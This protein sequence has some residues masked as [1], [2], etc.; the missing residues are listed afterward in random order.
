MTRPTL[1]D[2]AYAVLSSRLIPGLDGGYT[3][4]TLARARLLEEAGAGT[5]TLLTVDPGAP[6]AHAE[7]RAEFVRRGDA[8]SVDRFRNLFDDALAD[9]SWL[10]DAAV[11]G[12]PTP[13][14]GYR[15]VGGVVSI[16]VIP[17]DPDWHLTDAAV[18]VRGAGV[19]AGF[20][21]L[22]LA[23][24][25]HVVDELRADAPERVVVLVCE[26]R[27]LGELIAGWDDPGV[28]IVHTIHNS[29]LEPPYDDPDG[30]INALWR[31]WFAVAGSFDVVLW[32]TAAQREEVS[33]RFGG[34]DTYAVVP[35]AVEQIARSTQAPEPVEGSSPAH[36]AGRD[37]STGSTAVSHRVV[38]LN[39]LAPQKRVDHA[40]RAWA[41]VVE[42]VPDA[43][44]DVYGGGPLRDELQQLIE[45]LDLAGS[46]TLHG[47]VDD[48][49]AVFAGASLFLASSA[50]EGQGLSTA[51]AL[52]RGIPAVSYDVRYGPRE[53]IQDAGIV[54]PSGD[55]DGLADA[56]IALLRDD[57]RRAVLAARAP[58][59][60]ADLAPDVVRGLLIAAIEGAVSRPSRRTPS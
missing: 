17:G 52:A 44:L 50:Y 43:T 57:E 23:W 25:Q 30:P 55:I 19:I 47:H 14:V 49:E 39:R 46:V 38:M 22:Y 42:A 31:R 16:P 40:I 45:E 33:A 58:E 56:V 13:D 11:P 28:R 4:A 2:A 1:P 21:G 26:S 37:A 24:L 54:V 9:P 29:H 51:E 3:V 41:T 60:A 36:G 35:N 53:T 20:R 7:Q 59:V 27:Q 34:H 5:V 12:E 18:V 10:R 8:A 6:E 15:D 48:R 32:P